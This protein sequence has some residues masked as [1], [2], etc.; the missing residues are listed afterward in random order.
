MSN[1]DSVHFAADSTDHSS[2]LFVHAALVGLW[3]HKLLMTGI[4]V[5]S[6]VLGIIA[7]VA[8]PKQYTAEAHIR[9]EFL[10]SN[11][12]VQD[13]KGTIS[14]GPI[15]LD[16]ERIIETQSRLLQSQQVALR[17]VQQ[18]G[19]E[20]LQPV[21]SKH[22]WFL[23]NLTGSSAKTQEDIE[24]IAAAKLLAGLSVITDPRAYLLTVRYSA[25]DPE[26]AVLITD[27]F[28]A[29]LLRNARLQELSR[30]R[31]FA[32]ASLS[33][34]LAKFG[35]KHPRLV[36]VR[37]RLAMADDLM[38]EQLKESPE[39]I[40]KAAGE[41]VTNAISDAPRPRPLFVIGLLL[42]I[43]FVI[44]IVTVLWLERERLWQTLS[45]T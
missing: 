20:R 43:G 19:L 37:M 13:E 45:L 7:A 12:A 26:L 39:A 40:R 17:V 6:L 10:A 21:V 27:A 1:L 30:Q 38:K 42:L 2:A 3:R 5:A 31:A 25:D 32:E 14:I 28:V 22:R 29:E 41:N 4:I 23:P 36:N 16:L 44:S 34:Q 33:E 24:D 18:I 9:G 8:I 35:D 15:S 11:P